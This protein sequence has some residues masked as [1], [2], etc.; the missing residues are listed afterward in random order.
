MTEKEAMLA[1]ILRLR[2]V[3]AA[4]LERTQVDDSGEAT[5]L[6]AQVVRLDGGPVNPVFEIT[7]SGRILT[8]ADFERLADEE[9]RT[10]PT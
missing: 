9:A 6:L 4:A 10:W 3:A 7:E 1:E 5:M 2:S 8:D